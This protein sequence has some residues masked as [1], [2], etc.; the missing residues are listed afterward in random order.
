MV[1]RESREPRALAIWVG[2]SPRFCQALAAAS[3]SGVTTVGRPPARPWARA[4]VRPAAAG[5]RARCLVACSSAD[6]QNGPR[7]RAR[8][9]LYSEDVISW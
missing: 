4:V 8:A 5:A 2:V 7:P 9:I 6:I 1:A 3:V